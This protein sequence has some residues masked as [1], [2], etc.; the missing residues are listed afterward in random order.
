MLRLL[1]L[2]ALRATL[3]ARYHTDSYL[4]PFFTDVG[5]PPAAPAAS[6]PPA[7]AKKGALLLQSLVLRNAHTSVVTSP[8]VSLS[9]SVN[10]QQPLVVELPKVTRRDRS[11]SCEA[12]GAKLQPACALGELSPG[13]V[14]TIQAS[15]QP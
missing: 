13:D 11:Y 3:A 1:L 9:V 4:D 7:A 8:R 12:T 14:V 2:C 5:L 15:A 10:N 6:P